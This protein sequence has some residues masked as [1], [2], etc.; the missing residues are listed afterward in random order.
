M[1]NYS[2]SIRTKTILMILFRCL[3][4]G[5]PARYSAFVVSPRLFYEF[6]RMGVCV[7]KS[8]VYMLLMLLAVVRRYIK[9]TE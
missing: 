7:M 2:I 9:G 6:C 8:G 1:A 3:S 4:C 5:I